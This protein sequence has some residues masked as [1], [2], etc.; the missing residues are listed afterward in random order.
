MYSFRKLY[1]CSINVLSLSLSLYTIQVVGLHILYI[2]QY[3]ILTLQFTEIGTAGSLH[4]IRQYPSPLPLH[5]QSITTE[6]VS[7]EECVG[8]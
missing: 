2:S 5:Q 8:Q 6:G 7:T 1:L 3:S 4:N